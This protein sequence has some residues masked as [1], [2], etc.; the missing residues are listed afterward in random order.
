MAEETRA[1]PRDF[2]VKFGQGNEK[3]ELKALIWG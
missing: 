1:C 3:P 2:I